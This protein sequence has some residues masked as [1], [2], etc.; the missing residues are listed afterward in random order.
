MNQHLSDL[1][2]IAKPFIGKAFSAQQLMSLQSEIDAYL[3]EARGRGWNQGARAVASYTR[4]D[5]ILGKLTLK[6]KMVPPFSI[7]TI[8]VQTS[9]AA[10]ESEL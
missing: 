2:R 9:L 7:E 1:R 4:S 6:L 8:T 5:K 10:D 3:A